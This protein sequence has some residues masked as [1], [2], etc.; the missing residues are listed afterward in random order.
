MVTGAFGFSGKYIARHLLD[1]GFEVCT[2]TN[3]PNRSNP[4]GGKIKA[5][6][7]NFDAHEK[8]IEALNGA[9]IV[10]ENYDKNKKLMAVTVMYKVKNYNPGGGD[11]FWV[12][13]DAD[14][15]I[16]EEGKIKGCIDCHGTVKEND[17]IFTGKVTGK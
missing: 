5:F 17:Y 1:A 10:K 8:L 9:I 13:Y 7:Y 6:Q 16:L 14:F 3:S 11:W 4:F 2:L 15:E 12:K